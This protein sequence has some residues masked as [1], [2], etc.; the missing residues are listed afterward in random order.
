M[1]KIQP[2]SSYL[3]HIVI[4]TTFR[5]LKLKKQKISYIFTNC[6]GGAILGK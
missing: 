3:Y 4:K 6:C 1:K 5:L 2:A